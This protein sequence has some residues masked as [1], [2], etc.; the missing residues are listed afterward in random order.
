MCSA[1]NDGVERGLYYEIVAQRNAAL[2]EVSRLRAELDAATDDYSLTARLSAALTR[3]ANLRAELAA[4]V[5]RAQKRE[6]SLSSSVATLG[7]ENARLRAEVAAGN[8]W[9][10]ARASLLEELATLRAERGALRELLREAYDDVALIAE[11]YELAA[12][13]DALLNGGGDE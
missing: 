3:E 6:H 2:S 10:Q 4:V 13:I 5:E 1:T 11:N 9:I 7:N 8:E 12:R